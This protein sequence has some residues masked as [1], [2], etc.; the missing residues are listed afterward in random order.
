MISFPYLLNK[1]AT[2]ITGQRIF[3]PSAMLQKENVALARK[4]KEKSG[5]DV[6]RTAREKDLPPTCSA[7][8]A[9]CT[10]MMYGAD[11]I[12]VCPVHHRCTS[13]TTAMYATGMP[14]VER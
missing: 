9:G 2:R 3:V 7:G 10:S 13:R 11:S 6:C 4:L 12:D 1:I 5:M 8:F 14:P